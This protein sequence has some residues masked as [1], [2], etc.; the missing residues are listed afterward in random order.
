MEP[1]SIV[2]R[3]KCKDDIKFIA[4]PACDLNP[5]A[6]AF[7]GKQKPFHFYQFNFVV[8]SFISIFIRAFEIAARAFNVCPKQ[9]DKA[10]FYDNLGT[11]IPESLFLPI[12]N[13]FYSGSSFFVEVVFKLREEHQPSVITASVIID[14]DYFFYQYKS[15]NNSSEIWHTNLQKLKD[16]FQE[17]NRNGLLIDCKN[18]TKLG[19][20]LSDDQKCKCVNVVADYAIDIFGINIQTD[21]I[22]QLAYAA[23]TLIDGLKS[24][25]GDPIVS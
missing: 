11:L 8:N 12:L 7:R 14:S 13:T 16:Y 4:F 3:V 10:K 20:E 2:L 21:R 15:I 6:F 17:K 1:N 5:T 9:G 24:K 23:V 22:K 25:T 18:A 19:N